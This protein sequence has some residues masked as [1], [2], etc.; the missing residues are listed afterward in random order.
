HGF[1][2]RSEL[3]KAFNHAGIRPNV[4]FTATDADV[5][6]TYVRM[7]LGVGVVASMAI[8]AEHDRDL[9]AIPAGHLFAPSTTKIGFRKGTFLRSYMYDFL[10]GFAPHLTRSSV[11]EAMTKKSQ[12]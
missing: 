6:K 5:I 4:V 9:L 2:G 12:E 10:E 1:T 11:D 8:D 7:G 3:D